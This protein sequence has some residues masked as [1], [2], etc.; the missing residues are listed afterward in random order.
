MSDIRILISCSPGEVRIAELSDGE[1]TGLTLHRDGQETLVG[2]I[3]LGRVEAVIHNLQAAFV[4]IGL[5]RSGYLALAEVRPRDA[6]DDAIGDYL[7]EGDAVVVQVPRDPEAGK[8]AKLTA[9]PVLS[10]RDL[11]FT[12]GQPGISIS[13][14]IADAE[15]RDRLA[16]VMEG[17]D[18][19]A[20]GFI[21]RTAAEAAEDDDLL[22]EAERL[23]AEW[24]VID[25]RRGAA[26]APAVLRRDLE[27]A[28]RILREQ[29]GV[30]LGA[31]VVDDAEVC[32]RVKAFAAEQM[33]DI[34]DLI[35]AHKDEAG[36]FEAEGV[37][38]MI[39]QATAAKVRLPSGANIII[40]ETSSLTAIDVNSAG[41]AGGG[42]RERGAFEVNDE[43]AREIAH[44]IQLRNLSG[45]LVIDFITMRD[46]R[47]QEQVLETLRQA[48]ANDPCHPFVGG[49][50]RFGLVELTRRR[51]GASLT[52]IIF[53]GPAAAVPTP[54]STALEALR[55]VVREASA[56]AAP[57]LVLAAH[58]AVIETLEGAAAAA[59]ETAARKLGGGLE[60]VADDR[61]A[62]D[63]FEVRP[64]TGDTP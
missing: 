36:V 55:A 54:L 47:Y 9:R 27:P 40:D 56:S 52:E 61:L 62:R 25:D 39:D 50:T 32:A 43:A 30:D 58:S 26:K 34:A 14:R 33:P 49:F 64:A 22:A 17:Q 53:G 3:Y 18:D 38:E 16:A 24:S 31:V 11:V 1:L 28:C 51:Q 41:A 20:G 4:D 5:E 48:L 63:S 15:E 2:D 35:R 42:N 37:E 13:R 60:L 23:R 57:G 6:T 7:N 45:L 44:Q 19:A 21:L 46:K 8:G 10:G 59:R 12:P 29:G